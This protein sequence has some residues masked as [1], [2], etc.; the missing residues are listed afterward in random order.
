MHKSFLGS[1]STCAL[2]N[3]VELL[4]E[5][6]NRWYLQGRLCSQLLGGLTYSYEWSKADLAEHVTVG[7][8][9]ST[10]QDR[11]CASDA[12]VSQLVFQAYGR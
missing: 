12:I 4:I 6:G 9:L 11:L 1:R 8:R 3:Q 7:T 10:I 2:P 5:P